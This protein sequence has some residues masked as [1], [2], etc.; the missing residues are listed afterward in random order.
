M[1]ELVVGVSQLKS[2][3]KNLLCR[4]TN[5]QDRFDTTTVINYDGKRTET[6]RCLISCF[7]VFFFSLSRRATVFSEQFYFRIQ[8]QEAQCGGVPACRCTS[9]KDE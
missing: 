8:Q 4:V 5:E 2:L 1:G 9:D 7:F 6:G 3:W